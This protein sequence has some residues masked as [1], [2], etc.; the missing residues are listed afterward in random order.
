MKAI[1]LLGSLSL[2]LGLCLVAPPFVGPAFASTLATPLN[3]YATGPGVDGGTPIL[4][5]ANFTIVAVNPDGTRARRGGDPFAYT[6]TLDGAP[7]PHNTL[8]DN[9]DGTYSGGF[10]PV[11]P[12]GWTV[13]IILASVNIKGSPYHP[14][15]KIP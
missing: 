12:S 9:G 13:T 6:V 7:Y 1:K 4:Q 11:V 15:F 5:Q 10:T 3:S 14:T 8:R 2:F